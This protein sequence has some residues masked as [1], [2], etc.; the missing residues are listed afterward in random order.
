MTKVP[1]LIEDKVDKLQNRIE[2]NQEAELDDSHASDI[3]EFYTLEEF[4]ELNYKAM[5]YIGRKF[6]NIKFRRT[7]N[8]KSKAI[9]FR[10]QRGGSSR[11][12]S[13]SGYKTWMVNR[14][15]I[16]SCSFDLTI[17]GLLHYKKP[18]KQGISET[19]FG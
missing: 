11:C 1:E 8:C 13:R 5:T 15:K 6:R 16:D 19:M 12:S 3:S 17:K 7:L 10:F 4:E 9:A 18:N 14:N 2:G